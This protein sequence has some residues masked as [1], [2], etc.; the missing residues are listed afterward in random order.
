[1]TSHQPG[2]R[3]RDIEL[4]RI[5]RMTYDAGIQPAVKLLDK[6]AKYRGGGGGGTVHE[7]TAIRDAINDRI[8]SQEAG[9]IADRLRCIVSCPNGTCRELDIRVPENYEAPIFCALLLSDS[10]LTRRPEL[11]R[12]L[13]EKISSEDDA[14]SAADLLDH[15]RQHLVSCFPRVM[16]DQGEQMEHDG[17]GGD[18]DEDDDVSFNSNGGKM[19]TTGTGKSSTLNG[20]ILTSRRRLA[21]Y[22]AAVLNDYVRN[23]SFTSKEN[24]LPVM[25]SSQSTALFFKLYSRTFQEVLYACGLLPAHDDVLLW[26]IN[27]STLFDG[28]LWSGRRHGLLRF[29]GATEGNPFFKCIVGP[30]NENLSVNFAYDELTRHKLEQTLGKGD[31]DGQCSEQLRVDDGDAVD[32]QDKFSPRLFSDGSLIDVLS[33]NEL[34]VAPDICVGWSRRFLNTLTIAGHSRQGKYIHTQSEYDAPVVFVDVYDTTCH[35]ILVKPNVQVR[36]FKFNSLSH[37]CVALACF[38]HPDDKS[39]GGSGGGGGVTTELN[40]LLVVRKFVSNDDVTGSRWILDPRQECGLGQ[41]CLLGS[42]LPTDG[43]TSARRHV[44]RF[45]R[46]FKREPEYC[47]KCRRTYPLLFQSTNV[48]SHVVNALGITETIPIADEEYYSRWATRL[49]EILK[50]LNMTLGWLDVTRVLA[51][52]ITDTINNLFGQSRAKSAKF[53]T[54]AYNIKSLSTHSILNCAWPSNGGGGDAGACLQLWT[55]YEREILGP[56]RLLIVVNTFSNRE[57]EP[58][59][60][61]SVVQLPRSASIDSRSFLGGQQPPPAC[62][63]KSRYVFERGFDAKRCNVANLMTSA[64]VGGK[65]GDTEHGMKRVAIKRSTATAAAP[66]NSQP[67]LAGIFSSHLARSPKQQQHHHHT[68][69]RVQLKGIRTAVKFFVASSLVRHGDTRDRIAI[70]LRNEHVMRVLKVCV[71]SGDFR[72]TN[73]SRALSVYVDILSKLKCCAGNVQGAQPPSAKDFLLVTPSA[74]SK[75]NNAY[76]SNIGY[77]DLLVDLCSVAPK[78]TRSALIDGATSSIGGGTAVPELASTLTDFIYRW[79]RLYWITAILS[80]DGRLPLEVCVSAHL[81][82]QRLGYWNEPSPVAAAAAAASTSSQSYRTSNVW[83]ELVSGDDLIFGTA[84]SGPSI[85]SRTIHSSYEWIANFYNALLLNFIDE[86]THV[87]QQNA[88]KMSH[89]AEPLAAVKAAKVSIDM[90]VCVSSPLRGFCVYT[91]CATCLPP[92]HKCTSATFGIIEAEAG[93]GGGGGSGKSSVSHDSS[94]SDYVGSL[95]DARVWSVFGHQRHHPKSACWCCT[96]W[97]RFVC[98]DQERNVFTSWSAGRTARLLV[99]H[100]FSQDGGCETMIVCPQARYATLKKNNP[101]A[102]HYVNS[103]TPPPMDTPSCLSALDRLFCDSWIDMLGGGPQ[104]LSQAYPPFL[105]NELYR[106]AGVQQSTLSDEIFLSRTAKASLAVAASLYKRILIAAEN[107][108]ECVAR[109]LVPRFSQHIIETMIGGIVNEC[110]PRSRFKTVFQTLVQTA[111]DQ[112]QDTISDFVSWFA[113]HCL[114][115]TWLILSPAYNTKIPVLV[116]IENQ[117]VEYTVNLLI[118]VHTMNRGRITDANILSELQQQQKQEQTC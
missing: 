100:L 55:A 90:T 50:K 19:G 111:N 110:T 16:Y 84:A 1:M 29:L 62:T 18:N 36:K 21:E 78:D 104:K 92:P 40:C 28:D 79:I 73:L 39:D 68:F 3:S 69:H 5:D 70:M 67:F 8:M 94:V 116:M 20:S 108:P 98:I 66:A 31:K 88:P 9:G 60:N 10:H 56:S 80:D 44:M 38:I 105:Y 64:L 54:D 103:N 57:V 96:S 97:T 37:A 12:H 35:I 113:V 27:C 49:M 117:L 87:L 82:R 112:I 7:Q 59:S 41:R 22:N 43:K 30:M 115:E 89:H 11:V 23:Y 75:L 14:A 25:L 114:Y 102:A 83:L 51:P 76:S 42:L 17:G 63:Y 15:T 118:K 13:A 26:R 74:S 46:I 81:L 107:D 91:K 34:D 77:T 109:T 86:H 53:F 93:G 71:K 6:Q 45:D 2:Q 52:N 48:N 99:T 24:T 33:L 106:F 65:S 4:V 61:T 95:F 58:G 47:C 101:G 32:E 72:V 85:E